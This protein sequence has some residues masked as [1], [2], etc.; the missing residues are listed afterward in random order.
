MKKP[1]IKI[2]TLFPVQIWMLENGKTLLKDIQQNVYEVR[3]LD[4]K[5]LTEQ[6]YDSIVEKQLSYW[7]LRSQYRLT[8]GEYTI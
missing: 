1:L 2:Q 5:L 8:I 4:N 3:T 7:E 6:D